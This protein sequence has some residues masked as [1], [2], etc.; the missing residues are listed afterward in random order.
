VP[1]QEARVA[2]RDL[3]AHAPAI[4][5]VARLSPGDAREPGPNRTLHGDARRQPKPAL[6]NR[7]KGAKEA[8]L[9]HVVHIPRRNAAPK[10]ERAEQIT[11]GVDVLA[12]PSCSRRMRVL[13]VIDNAAV[14]KK[15]LAHLGLPFDPLPRA[16]PKE[17]VGLGFESA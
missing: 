17:Q 13:S 9:D 7:A 15:I 4:A 11:L 10:Q 2:R 16:P 6:L 14:A 3:Q 8:L 1:E 12:C 5:V